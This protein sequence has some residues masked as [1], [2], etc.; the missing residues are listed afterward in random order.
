M[1]ASV[2]QLKAELSRF[3]KRAAAGERV[4]VTSRGRPIAQ[5]IAAVTLPQEEPDTAEIRRR[6]ASIPGVILGKP[7]K[8]KGSARPIR[9][10][11]G[12]KPVSQT[13]LDDRR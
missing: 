8:V 9:L 12:A 4:I 10:R 7:G 3:L 1:N 6:L 13:V 2:R 11:K 5:V